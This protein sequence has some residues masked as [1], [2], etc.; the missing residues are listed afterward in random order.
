MTRDD[1]GDETEV[2]VERGEVSALDRG[3]LYGDG[4]FETFRCYDGGVA[5]LDRH[6]DRLQTALDAVG[7]EEGVTGCTPMRTFRVK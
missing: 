4:V 7:I 5:F 6:L 2:W 1:L 3:L